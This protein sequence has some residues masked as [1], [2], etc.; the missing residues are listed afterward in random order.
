MKRTLALSM[1]VYVPL[2]RLYV[3]DEVLSKDW[4]LFKLKERLTKK[5]AQEAMTQPECKGEY[6]LKQ[7]DSLLLS[8]TISRSVLWICR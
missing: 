5:V 7:H 6:K 1:L 3:C 4:S 8:R 2:V